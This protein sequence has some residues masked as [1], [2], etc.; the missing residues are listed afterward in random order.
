MRELVR[1]AREEGRTTLTEAESKRLL[2][3]AGVSTP[4]FEVASTSDE[5]VAAADRLGY[6]VVVKVSSP[7]VTHKTEW[8]DGA[9]V[10]LNLSSPD[11]VA[12][13]A[14][15]IF[16]AA[17]TASINA[18][19]LVEEAAALDARTEL[20]V[21]GLRNPS[22]GPVVLVGLGGVVT[23]VFEDT[24]HRL[25]PVS[26]AEARDAV[27]ELTAAP[28]LQGY[29][30]RTPADIDTLAKVVQTVGDIVV[31][32]PAIAEIDVNP[33]LA[34]PDNAIALDAAILLEDEDENEE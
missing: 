12:D 7:A 19:V 11:A 17:R 16:T 33:V 6:P 4:T 24:A 26:A 14:D 10:A 30:D 27:Q 13:A 34:G 23:E 20:I 25:A 28:L 22:F 32:N 18:D 3:D 29:R 8:G 15:S 1:A 5:A 21:G 9:G 2:A 31:D